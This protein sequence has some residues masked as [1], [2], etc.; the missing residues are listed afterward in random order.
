MRE[1]DLPALAI[2]DPQTFADEQALHG[3]L[4]RLRRTD[5]LPRIDAPGYSP[6]WLVTRHADIVAVEKAATRFIN[7]PRQALLPDAHHEKT[8]QALAG[9]PVGEVMRNLTAMDGAEHR[10]Y[11]AIAQAEFMPVA[12][13]AI[14]GDIERLAAEFVDR[15]AA[16]GEACDFATDIAFGYPLRVI[17]S[18]LGVPP[19]DEPLM[20]KLTQRLLTSQDP[21][22]AG[23][24]NNSAHAVMEMFEYMA[25]IVARRRTE[26]E[27]DIA[28]VIANARIDD[29]YLPDRDVLGYFLII[30]TAGH[31]TTSYTLTGGLLAL[32]QHPDQLARLRAEPSL[33]PTAIEEILRWTSAVRHFCRTATEDCEVAGQRIA[34]GDLLLLSY[35]SANRDEAAFDDPDA[36]RIDRRPNKQLAFGT[37]PH[38]CLGQYLARMELASFLREFLDRVEDIE[39]AGTPRFTQSTFVG[40]V[41]NLPIRYRM[42]DR[43]A[44]SAA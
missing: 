35:P 34:K 25:P 32:L 14:R 26:P 2:A 5:P 18:I 30:A 13:N 11:R 3:L 22:L 17:M 9:R 29:A 6:F 36:F 27:A 4:A 20:L 15:M 37:G 44:R 43:E 7:A 33:M 21:E 24:D 16:L 10:A 38:V 12:M 19:E 42:R 40:G 8:R 1:N 41:K 23:K 28:S 31:D 39:L